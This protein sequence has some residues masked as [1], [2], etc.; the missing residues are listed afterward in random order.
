MIGLNMIQF[1]K[2]LQPDCKVY[3]LERN[4]NK[5]EIAKKLGADEILTGD[6][7]TA[8]A[9]A[10]GGKLYTK[11][12]YQM[13][14]GGFDIIY[15]CVG[16]HDLFNNTL[17]W[18]KAQ[19]TLVKVG[20]QMTATT[21]D[22]TPIWWQGLHIIGADSHGLEDFNGEKI[23]TFELVERMMLNKQITTE[24]FITHKFKLKDYKEA[25]KLLIENP[26]KTIKVVLECDE[27]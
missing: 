5:F 27:C 6:T 13:I 20:Y 4:P 1:A 21:F 23:N 7:F 15:D 19:G 22:E 11:G 3:V 16:K 12:K 8:V 10:T 26:S 18:L 9:N 17:K 2:V 14:L 25:F 24:G